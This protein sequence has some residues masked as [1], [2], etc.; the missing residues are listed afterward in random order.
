MD[1]PLA[2]WWPVSSPPAEHERVMTTEGICA[3]GR[4]D[5]GQ[6]GWAGIEVSQLLVSSSLISW[7]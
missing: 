4:Q 2:A 5:V 1:R 6:E 3:L 7:G